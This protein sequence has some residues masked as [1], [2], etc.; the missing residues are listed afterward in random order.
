MAVHLQ[1]TLTFQDYVEA[2]RLHAKRG[3]WPRLNLILGYTL[4]P[5]IGVLCIL[6]A[7]FAIRLADSPALFV[8]ELG[9][10]LF[11]LCYPL[12]LRL[13][14]KRCYLRTRTE[15]AEC[16]VEFGDSIIRTH[17]TT[18]RSEVEWSAVRS[19][20]ENKNLFLV[21]LAPAKFIPVPKRVCSPQQIEELQSLFTRERTAVH[22]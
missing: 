3:W 21:Y 19:I 18:M 8:F 12:Y 2:Q 11:L 20:A 4:I 9:V 6:I 7:L 17:T 5:V 16:S 14:W 13:R 22:Q 1:F 10:G 15:P